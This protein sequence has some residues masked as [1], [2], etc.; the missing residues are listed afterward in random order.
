MTLLSDRDRLNFDLFARALLRNLAGTLE[1][2]VGLRE[3]EGFVATVGARLGRELDQAYRDAH[4][5][6]ELDIVD[7]AEA[8]VDLKR[9]IGGEFRIVAVDDQRILLHN[10]RCPFGDAVLDRPSLC[11]M[12][13]NV[14]GRL[15]ADNLGYA[16]VDLAETIARG[17]GRCVVSIALTPEAEPE[18]RTAREYF[19]A[20]GEGS[21]AP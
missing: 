4:D 7:V 3:A 21:D 10:T 11:M 6:P 20:E 16:R 1:S 15:T 19:R 12:T 18:R 14:F 9:R 17:D 13:S 8:L 2:L 5:V